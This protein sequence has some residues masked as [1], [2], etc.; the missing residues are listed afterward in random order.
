MGHQALQRVAV[1]MFYDPSFVDRVYADPRA[2]T[3]DC[4]L[5]DRERAWL[6]RPDRRAWGVDPLRAARSLTTLVEEFPVATARWITTRVDGPGEGRPVGAPSPL[7]FFSDP[8]FHEGMQRGASLAAL[9]ARWLEGLE[10]R[11]HHLRA[12]VAIEAALARAR[13]ARAARGQTRGQGPR[14]PDSSVAPGDVVLA[15]GCTLIRVPAGTVAG[16][17]AV[18]EGL[19][20]DP[21][22]LAE[23]V[24]APAATFDVPAL[25]SAESEA[26]LVDVREDEGRLEILGEEL[27]ALLQS[28]A[29]AMTPEAW[30]A[31]AEALGATPAQAEGLLSDF[32]DEGVLV[33]TVG[34]EDEP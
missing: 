24:I 11:D 30:L 34:T 16:Y 32:L 3:A 23:A 21:R 33:R 29:L 26:V 6:V 9:Y 27:A 12:F 5:D 15:A 28:S 22:P 10:P 1:R 17:A 7:Q 19:R 25:G 14:R 2:A 20:S 13:R 18:L 31:R 4:E 8:V